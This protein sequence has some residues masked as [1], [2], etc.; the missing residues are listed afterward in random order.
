MLIA[1]AR[2][3]AEA[4]GRPVCCVLQGEDLFLDGLIEPYRTAPAISSASR[5]GMS[6]GSSP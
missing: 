5:S 2:P 1:P 4:F 6:I 3:L